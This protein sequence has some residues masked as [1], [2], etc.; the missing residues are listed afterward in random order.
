MRRLTTRT[1]ALTRHFPTRAARALAA[2]AAF[3]SLAA[4]GD[5]TNADSGKISIVLTD[6]P[7]D[8]EKAVVTVSEIYL[9]GSGGKVVLMNTPVTTDLLTLANSTAELVKDATVPAG[10]YAELRFVVTG[11]YVEVDDGNGGSSIYASS[12]TY[13]GLPAGAHV[14]GTLQMPSYAQT[15]IKVT[16]PGGAVKISGEQKVLLVDFDVAQ[17][18]GKLS[19]GSGQWAMTPVIKA[20]D[21]SFS[22]GI[23]ATLS[24]GDGVTMPT[25]NSSAMTLGDVTAVLSNAQ[26]SHETLAFTDPD[27]DGVYEA[28][29]KYLA[30]GGFTL[31]LAGPSGVTLATDP[32]HPASVSVQSGQEVTQAFRLTAAAAQ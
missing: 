18:F 27:G 24:K 16:T 13:A 11:G 31:D 23:V 6:A 10:T 17:S 2:A 29:F 3:V 7:G 14:A 25:V 21:L 8:M 19:G 5:S 4:C 9:Q 28:R 1:T 12:P 32:S 20:T 22:G 15:G 30:P 26:G